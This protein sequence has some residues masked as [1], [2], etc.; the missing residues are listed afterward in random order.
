VRRFIYG[1]LLKKF[2]ICIEREDE[3]STGLQRLT[4]QHHF[5]QYNVDPTFVGL[6]IRRPLSRLEAGG[7]KTTA[8]IGCAAVVQGGG[9]AI[10]DRDEKWRE[11][12]GRWKGEWS[13][14]LYSRS[15]GEGGPPCPSRHAK[16]S[17]LIH[18]SSSYL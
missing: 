15:G 18:R 17:C 10:G 2:V 9:V 3:A 1:D 8:R 4:I 16:P 6:N 7:S 5:T 11:I 12:E 14:G 13:T